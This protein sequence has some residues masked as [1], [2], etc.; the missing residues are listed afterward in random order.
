MLD[1]MY[2]TAFNDAMAMD[3]TLATVESTYFFQCESGSNRKR[4][5]MCIINLVCNNI[6]IHH[7]SSTR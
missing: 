7:S 1:S 5:V 2:P 3:G 4:G 6:S